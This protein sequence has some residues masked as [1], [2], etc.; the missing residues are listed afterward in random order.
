MPQP[1]YHCYMFS[2]LIKYALNMGFECQIFI[3]VNAQ[4]FHR[5]DRRN[6]SI[7]H[8]HTSFP[9]VQERPQLCLFNMNAQCFCAIHNGLCQ[10]LVCSADVAFQVKYHLSHHRCTKLIQHH[11]KS[12]ENLSR[13]TE[14]IAVSE[15]N[16]F[17]H[18]T[19]HKFNRQCT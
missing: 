15:S 6:G 4:I 9:T 2:Q 5:F 11:H 8:F 1:Q 14:T 19:Q 7:C 12:L 13:I 17:V 3:H 16:F 18:Q 10:T